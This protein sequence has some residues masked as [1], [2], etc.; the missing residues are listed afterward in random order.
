MWRMVKNTGIFT[1][2]RE[3][4]QQRGFAGHGFVYL[5]DCHVGWVSGLLRV[6]PEASPG[7]SG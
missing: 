1:P 6:A 2:E 7:A 5:K 3:R 4:F